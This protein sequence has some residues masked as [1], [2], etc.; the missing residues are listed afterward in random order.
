MIT[1]ELKAKLAKVYELAKRGTDGEK[2]A[3]EALL[4]KLLN[5]H[6]LAGIDLDSLD[7]ER[8]VFTYTSE[9]EVKLMT[10][11]MAYILEKPELIR[12][13]I[14]H[15]TRKQILC[16]LTYMDYI[17]LSCAY[18]Y[19]RG[20]MK[21]QWK[22]VC[23][24]EVKRRRKAKTKNKRRAELQLYFFSKYIIASGLC[25]PD[26]I[27]YKE[28]DENSKEYADMVRMQKVQG[29]SYKTQVHSGHLI[30]N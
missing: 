5:K 17:K 29:G 1:P 10:R 6:N 28:V 8:Y 14:R 12:E 22:I 9:I 11:I 15:R 18:E 20:H 3:A 30:G 24:A 21:T 7:K 25:K 19:F 27:E 23:A 4:D 16:D 26:E 13:S 2:Q